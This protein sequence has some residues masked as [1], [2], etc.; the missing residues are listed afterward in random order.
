MNDGNRAGVPRSPC[1]RYTT[2]EKG[3]PDSDQILR[4]EKI[5]NVLC[6]AA[7]A[8]KGTFICPYERVLEGAQPVDDVTLLVKLAKHSTTVRVWGIWETWRSGD[9]T[10][11]AKP[12]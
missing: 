7:L 12:S 9:A 1:L 5:L 11:D 3:L 10:F 6:S 8:C 2:G 4:I